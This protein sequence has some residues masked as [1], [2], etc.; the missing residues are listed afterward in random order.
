MSLL[1]QWNTIKNNIQDA[2]FK[3]DNIQGGE[4]IPD[5][6]EN[7]NT[8]SETYLRS[9][10][11]NQNKWRCTKRTWAGSR[12]SP[13]YTQVGNYLASGAQYRSQDTSQDWGWGDNY[14]GVRECYVYCSQDYTLSTTFWS[15]DEGRI[16]LNGSSIATSASCANTTVSLPFKKGLNHVEMFFSEQ[17]GGDGCYITTNLFTQSWVKWGYA[18]Y[19]I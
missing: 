3:S 18:C 6:D 4:D 2:Y 12:V 13:S 16:C 17:S 5:T 19:K 10:F 11:Q 1:S 14:I 7:V 15:D 8:E 9:L